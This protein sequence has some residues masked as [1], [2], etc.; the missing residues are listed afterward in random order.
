LRTFSG[1]TSDSTQT[2]PSSNSTVIVQAIVASCGRRAPRER[3]AE[4]AAGREVHR[5]DVEGA[6]RHDLDLD[7]TGTTILADGQPAGT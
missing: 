1:L 3:G 4:P 5:L 2:L 6:I 7:N